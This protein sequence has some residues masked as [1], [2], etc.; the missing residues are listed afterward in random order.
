MILR[1]IVKDTRDPANLGR[2]K[3]TIPQQSGGG[4]SGWI[5]P[6]VTSGYIVTPRVGD[7]VWVLFEQGDKE[8]PVWIGKTKE[9]SGYKTLL[10]RVIDLEDEVDSLKSRVSALEN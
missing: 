8:M 9:T 4:A 6:V 3:V 2:I 5:Y 10:Q 7:Q 1:A